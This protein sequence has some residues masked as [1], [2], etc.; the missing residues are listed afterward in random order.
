MLNFYGKHQKSP[1][2]PLTYPK[3]FDK[4][5]VVEKNFKNI[6]LAERGE[7]GMRKKKHTPKKFEQLTL[8]DLN[9]FLAK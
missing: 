4:I 9:Q 7:T 3:P 5:E 6:S 1:Q 2:N 8:F